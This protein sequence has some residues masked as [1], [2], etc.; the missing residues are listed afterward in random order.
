MQ[1]CASAALIRRIICWIID[2]LNSRFSATIIESMN[3]EYKRF[4]CIVCGWEYD[5]RWAD[6]PLNWCCP[7]CGAVKDDFDMV[8]I[9]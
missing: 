7:D 8:E 4:M 9:S 6:V 5:E 2:L 3:N 1:R